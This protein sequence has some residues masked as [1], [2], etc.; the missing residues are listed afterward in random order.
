[1]KHSSTFALFALVLFLMPLSSEAYF[2]RTGP[3]KDRR[4][5]IS[6]LQR[7]VVM[8]DG[9][10]A[11]KEDKRGK[12][13]AFTSKEQSG[14]VPVRVKLFAAADCEI[15]KLEERMQKVWK[16]AG[17]P[18]EGKAESLSLPGVQRRGFSWTEPGSAGTEIHWCLVTPRQVR[19]SEVSTLL[20]EPALVR[21]IQASFL[22]QFV[23]SE[24]SNGK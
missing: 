21:K 18:V 9:W 11:S 8:P 5:Y 3:A 7:Y 15:T 12:T 16:E 24:R 17:K 22:T 20:N 1:M 23:T 19:S 14:D 4:V 6:F 2:Q 13:I 10:V